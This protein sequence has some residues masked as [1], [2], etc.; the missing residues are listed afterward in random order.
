[1]TSE[2]IWTPEVLTLLFRR[3]VQLYGPHNTWEGPNAALPGR[4]R[5]QDFA[6][7]CDA[8]AQAVGANSGE[9]VQWKVQH[10]AY[11]D[12]TAPTAAEW[13]EKPEVKM[14]I[15]AALAAGFIVEPTPDIL[16]WNR[17]KLRGALATGRPFSLPT[18]HWQACA[19]R[20]RCRHA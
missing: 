20:R 13:H 19:E 16:P 6:K 11:R 5:N 2:I 18:F 8:F 9:A 3:L 15:E 10:V 14:C 17:S 12:S 7:F 4:G 1:M